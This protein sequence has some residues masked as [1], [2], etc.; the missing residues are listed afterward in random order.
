MALREDIATLRAHADFRAA[1][2]ALAVANGEKLA[3]MSVIERWMTRDLGR[4]GLSGAAIVLDGYSQGQGM[5]F[6]MLV[7]AA[8]HNRICSRA[9]VRL[10]VERAIANGLMAPQTPGEPLSHATRIDI[11]PLFREVMRRGVRATLA[12]LVTLAPDVQPAVLRLDELSFF[13]RFSSAVGLQVEIQ[14]ELFPTD[15]P[16]NLFLSRDG[17]TRMLEHL[18]C[19]QEPGR[20]RLL[21]SCEMSRSVLARASFSSRAH[22]ARLL[23]ELEREGLARMDRR[24]MTVAR[25]LSD[26]VERHYATMFAVARAAA[27][28]ALETG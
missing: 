26:D 27:L 25:E 4:S 22:V 10:Y 13:G 1:V 23:G 17:G 6:G 19:L 28:S 9:R 8:K 11:L 15:G 16:V 24:R 14:R 3:A 7:D 18:I 12:S 2:E 5:T 21:Q 20:D